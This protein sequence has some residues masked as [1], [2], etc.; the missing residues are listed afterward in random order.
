MKLLILAGG[1]GT[2]LWPLSRI[3][4]P[5]QV[6]PFFD[7]ST[8][9]Q[10]TWARLRQ[11]YKASDIFISTTQLN[12]ALVKKQLPELLKNHL[13][14]EPVAR[15]TAPAIAL[16]SKIIGELYPNEVIG[17]IN[18]DHF[19]KDEKKY[20]STLRLAEKIVQK[21]PASIL[22]MGL[23]PTYAE[24]GYGYIQLAK[25][26]KKSSGA[27]KVVSFTEKP[28]LKTAT[29]YLTSKKYLWNSGIFFFK[30]IELFKK[31]DKFA[32]HL[33]R[34]IKTLK[35]INKSG[36]YTA[37]VA[38][39][40]KCQSL[41]FDYAV[42]EKTKDLLVIPASFGWA[43][44]GHWRTM[45]DILSTPKQPNVVKG[46]YLGVESKGNLVYSL[47]GRLV[48][49]VGVNNFVVIDTK[50]ALLICPKNQTQDVKKLVESLKKSQHRKHL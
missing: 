9:L 49:T 35:V 4:S 10:H 30:P 15:N 18:S 16:A 40:S 3:T 27:V 14:I 2:R 38:D 23:E 42:V 19:I 44:V 6:Q 7:N 41:A 34:I 1:S 43:D 5:K 36:Y 26:I 50:D 22:L 33:A 11:A 45:Y 28:N 32:P 8:L 20:L 17:T 48:T 47:G 37:M 46:H 12:A 25:A 39:F 21:N 31:I 24:I 13:I 29:K